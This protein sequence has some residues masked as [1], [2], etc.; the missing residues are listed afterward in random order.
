MARR[1]RDPGR[2][3]NQQVGALHSLLSST[4]PSSTRPREY[5][6]GLVGLRTRRRWRIPRRRPDEWTETQ[7]LMALKALEES[8]ASH[9]R[10]IS[11]T[12]GTMTQ[13]GTAAR[14]HRRPSHGPPACRQ[15]PLSPAWRGGREGRPVGVH[16]GMSAE[17]NLR[18]RGLAALRAGYGRDESL[19][20]VIPRAR[21]KPV[22]LGSCVAVV[23]SRRGHGSGV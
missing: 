3:L 20:K 5:L 19:G 8:R 2:P 23:P 18:R 1:A 16:R 15:L 22:S 4:R 14:Q 13:R 9:L 21:S 10:S 11:M 6:R 12:A 17:S 7:L